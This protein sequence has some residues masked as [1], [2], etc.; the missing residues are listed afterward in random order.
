MKT[1][2]TGSERNETSSE[3]QEIIVYPEAV[4]TETCNEVSDISPPQV[5]TKKIEN[6]RIEVNSGEEC[7]LRH[8]TTEIDSH[9][10]DASEQY[11]EMNPEDTAMRKIKYGHLELHKDLINDETVKSDGISN[12]QTSKAPERAQL[13]VSDDIKDP[14][15]DNSNKDS[16]TDTAETASIEEGDDEYMAVRELGNSVKVPNG[17]KHDIKTLANRNSKYGNAAAGAMRDDDDDD[18]DSDDANDKDGDQCNIKQRNKL[19]AVKG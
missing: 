2:E 12:K 10:Y 16:D 13:E 15:E 5:I 6:K 8:R 19:T 9:M 14:N 7:I 4:S 17:V 18:V 3:Q 11:M 1:H